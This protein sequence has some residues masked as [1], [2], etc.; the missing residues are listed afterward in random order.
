[1]YVRAAASYACRPIPTPADTVAMTLRRKVFALAL[2]VIG[3]AAP[4]LRAQGAAAVPEVLLR[5]DD[6]GMNHS[7]N[8]AV[9]RVAA[10]GMPI[11]VSVMFACPWYEEAVAILQKH[12][13]VTVGVHLV[14][15]SEWRNYRWGPVLGKTAVPS[16][17]DSVGYFLPSTASFV[18]RKPNLDE[19]ERELSAQMDRAM[20]SGLKIAYVDP[21]MGAAT[22]TPELRAVAERVARKYGVGISRYFGE[23]AHTTFSTPIDAKKA[24]LLAILGRA[25]PKRTNLVVVH[26]AERTPEMDVLF[27][28]NN[29]AQNSD[30]G[31]PMVARHRQGELDML[32]SPELAE[33]VKSGKVRLTTYR[34]VID[35]AGGPS[36][37]RRPQ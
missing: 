29:A 31:L 24:E 15:N 4:P 12:P 23:V 18:A 27:D 2:V 37:M 6:M 19:V 35:R 28:R 13:N 5:L 17:V 36:A 25:D 21:H 1:L 30:D 20:A 11:S 33:Q 9:G 14:L 8:T 16:L 34:Q 22:A 3:A 10:T 32:L 26:V 7:V